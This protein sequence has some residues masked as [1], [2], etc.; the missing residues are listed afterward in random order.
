MATKLKQITIRKAMFDNSTEPKYSGKIEFEDGKHEF[1]FKL[2]DKRCNQFLDL[3]REDVIK[4][5]TELGNQL[6]AA[7]T[8]KS[9]K[10]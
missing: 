5:A 7:I 8:I 2:D 6:A 9:E 1:S 10:K 4:T 3:I